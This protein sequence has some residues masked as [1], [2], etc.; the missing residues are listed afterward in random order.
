MSWISTGKNSRNL[1]VGKFLW[2]T[3]DFKRVSLVVFSLHPVKQF[4]AFTWRWKLIESWQVPDHIVTE[5]RGWNTFI[6]CQTPLKPHHQELCLWKVNERVSRA[7]SASPG[8]AREFDC[9]I[10]LILSSSGS[11]PCYS[12]VLSAL[13]RSLGTPYGKSPSIACCWRH[14]GVA[15][16]PQ[17]WYPIVSIWILAPLSYSIGTLQNLLIQIEPQLTHLLKC[18][19]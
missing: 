5:N 11:A 1:Q 16:G 6:H 13:F 2:N 18:K 19:W 12:E 9:G 10:Q 15:V 7:P 14:C 8:N 3:R 17:G 4:C